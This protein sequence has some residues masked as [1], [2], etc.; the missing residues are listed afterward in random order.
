MA[1]ERVDKLLGRGLAVWV[2]VEGEARAQWRL[3]ARV[4]VSGVG[5]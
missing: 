4:L 5:G 1:R 3:G 2:E